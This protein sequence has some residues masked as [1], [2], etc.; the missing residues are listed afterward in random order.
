M[1]VE[2]DNSIFICK[3]DSLASYFLN[4]LKK[5][6]VDSIISIL[7]DFDNG[8]VEKS[9]QIIIWI[10]EGSSNVKIIAGC[11]LITKDSV[12]NFNFL[13]LLTYI[14]KS[15]FKDVS[16]PI[17]SEVYISHDMCYHIEVLFPN[18]KFIAIVRDYERKQNVA[19]NTSLTDT[20]IVLANM[21]DKLPK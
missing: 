9:R 15:K 10:H 7:Y 19:N 3:S 5:Q 11:D 8:R 2:G 4:K 13:E 12:Y 17:P 6:K 21:I 16:V 18:K 14:N 1:R 20:R